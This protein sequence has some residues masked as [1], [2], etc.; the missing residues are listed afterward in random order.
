MGSS[1]I[2]IKGTHDSPKGIVVL[3]INA[4]V[5][6]VVPL[7]LR[8]LFSGY[9]PTYGGSVIDTSAPNFAPAF[10]LLV[11]VMLVLSG[12]A[13]LMGHRPGRSLGPFFE[14]SVKD[15]PALVAD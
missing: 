9:H 10:N 3:L 12:I 6:P 4:R 1:S 15:L 14:D 5:I 8:L 7:I 11:G 13:F 2:V